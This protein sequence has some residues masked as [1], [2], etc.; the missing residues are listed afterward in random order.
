SMAIFTPWFSAN[1]ACL[2]QYGVTFLSHCHSSTSRYSGGHGH[3]TQFGYFAVSLSP[4]QPEKSI[5]TGTPS[6][7]ASKMVFRLVSWFFFATSGLGCSGFPWQLRALMVKPLSESFFL[8]SIS[9]V[10]LSSIES[11]Q[12]G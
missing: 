10:L 6:F 5:T 3:V 8:N 12:C 7:S 9:S 1:L 2:I 4:G 11:L